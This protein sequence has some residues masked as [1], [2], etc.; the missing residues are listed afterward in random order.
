MMLRRHE[1]KMQDIDLD[2]EKVEA[3]SKAISVES[4]KAEIEDKR[5]KGR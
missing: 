5:A 4:G 3:S 2:M 1:L